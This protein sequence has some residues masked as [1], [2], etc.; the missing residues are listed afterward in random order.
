MKYNTQQRRLPLP[1]YGRS[2]QN[3]VD[4]A[5]TIEDRAERQRCANTIVNIMGGMFPHLRDVADFKQKLWDH[6]AIM[7]DFKL[8]I[9]YPVEIVKKE[10]LEIKPQRIPYSQHDIRFRH[11]GRFVQDMIK[12]AVDYQAGE[13]RNQLIRMIANHMKRDYLNWN[14]DG[15]EDQKILDDLCELSGGKIKLSAEDLRLTEQRTFIPR[16]RQMNNNNNQGKKK[17]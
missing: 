7:A 14:K 9:D 4:H 16:R 17:Y 8:D 12:L 11:Y 1:E 5:L 13:E 6:L 3:M 15:V 10:S 2:V